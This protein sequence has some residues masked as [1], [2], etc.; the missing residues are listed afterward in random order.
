MKMPK[1]ESEKRDSEKKEEMNETNFELAGRVIGA[2]YAARGAQEAGRR[3]S[4]M[5]RILSQRQMPME[6][7]SDAHIELL[8][9]ELALMDSNNFVGNAGVG[10]REGR[11]FS[12]LV[13]RRH[14][15]FSH[16]VGRS[17]ELRADAAESGRLVAHGGRH[18]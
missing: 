4:A 17:G 15:D 3:A 7:W 9:R 6:G 10:E 8:L 12:S 1:K 5:T 18:V 16:G 13:K 14:F 2:S 11:V